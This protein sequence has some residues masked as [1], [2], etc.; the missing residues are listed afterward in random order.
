MFKPIWVA[1]VNCRLLRSL[2]H[3]NLSNHFNC[4]IA[5]EV[6]CSAQHLIEDHPKAE[7]VRAMI[8]ILAPHLLGRH[9]AYGSHH[10]ARISDGFLGGHLGTSSR[11]RFRWPQF[12]KTEIENL[13]SSV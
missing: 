2:F 11:S 9:V 4:G 12:S 5:G 7:D 1:F 3:Q 8:G 6:T 13:R 10:R